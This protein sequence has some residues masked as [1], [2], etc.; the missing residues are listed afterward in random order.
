MI[1]REKHNLYKS[2]VIK[3]VGENATTNEVLDY[4]FGDQHSR[5]KSNL[6][7]STWRENEKTKLQRLNMVWVFPF[8]ILVAP[9]NYVLYG[10]VGWDDKTRLGRFLLRITGHLD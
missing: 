1:I 3:A 2:Q 9:I 4:L 7:I 8:T 6:V 10:F 5:G